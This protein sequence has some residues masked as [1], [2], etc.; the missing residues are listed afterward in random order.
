MYTNKTVLSESLHYSNVVFPNRAGSEVRGLSKLTTDYASIHHGSE[1][2]IEGGATETASEKVQ[3]EN[4][5]KTNSEKLPEEEVTYGN[6]TRQPTMEQSQ[7][8]LVD[9]DN[10]DNNE[11]DDYDDDDDIKYIKETKGAIERD[12]EQHN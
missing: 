7:F 6:I 1:Q 8:E 12:K 4:V 2:Q 10:N 5:T 11:D 3:E 9:D